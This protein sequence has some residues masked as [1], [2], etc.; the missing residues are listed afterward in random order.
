M[1]NHNT[2]ITLD[3]ALKK[4]IE[5]SI[6][7][8]EVSKEID[9]KV[10]EYQKTYKLDGFREGKVPTNLIRQKHEQGLLGEVS[11]EMVNNII[12]EILKER[13]YRLALSPK[14]DFKTL[15]LN[16]DM[17]FIVIFELLPEVPEIKYKKI[18]L[19]K[20]I[21]ELN[22]KDINESI[23]K[24]VAGKKDWKEEEDAKAKAKKGDSVEI[25][26]LGKLKGVPFEGG[27]AKNYRLELGSDSFIKGFEDQLIGKKVGDDVLVKVKFPK[28]YH[29]EDLSGKA[30]EF[31]VKIHKIFTG[32]K[33]ELTNEFLKKN[34]NVD[35]LDK[36]KEMIKEQTQEMYKNI[37]KENIKSDLFDWIKNNVKVEMPVGLVEDQFT[38]IWKGIE[39]EIRK[40][41][42]KFAT[43]KD[44]EKAKKENYKL[45]EDMVKVGLI[46]SEI[47]KVNEL[48]ISNKEITDVI[49]EKARNFPGQEELFINYYKN[50]KD[51]LSDITGALLEDKVVDFMVSKS[52]VKEVKISAKEFQKRQEKRAKKN[53]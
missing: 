36:L 19:E 37:T 45:A 26:F 40:N 15:E 27:E 12:T 10:N 23:E 4:E 51:A 50:N 43:E 30:V 18:S 46:L 38:R 31:E 7:F 20:E 52:N 34:F 5:I 28:E 8:A 42:T 32:S 21:V 2:R 3:E 47:G 17:V 49:Q 41:P 25:D 29:K 53:K 24:L 39:E 22:E 44:K 14:V 16:K 13:D 48:K 11:E 33:P 6:S 35:S 1:S 9:K